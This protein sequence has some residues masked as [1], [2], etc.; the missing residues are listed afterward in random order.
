MAPEGS[1]IPEQKGTE[2]FTDEKFTVKARHGPNCGI[3]I[4]EKEWIN[5]DEKMS[6]ISKEK[7]IQEIEQ[8]TKGTIIKATMT[9]R[10]KF[11]GFEIIT[12]GIEGYGK[13]GDTSWN[14]NMKSFNEILTEF[15]TKYS[16]YDK[17]TTQPTEVAGQICVRVT[18][19]V[20]EV[21]TRDAIGEACKADL[22][23]NIKESPL[24]MAET[25]AYGRCMR[26]FLGENTMKEECDNGEGIDPPGTTKKEK[27]KTFLEHLDEPTKENPYPGAERVIAP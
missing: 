3:M 27:Q 13:K 19:E 26:W 5:F 9:S 18:L 24:R 16:V 23:G 15:N 12:K 10:T 7:M 6:G 21:G 22:K 20:P 17:L 11:I 8:L 14:D 1:D 2:S 4:G 25:R